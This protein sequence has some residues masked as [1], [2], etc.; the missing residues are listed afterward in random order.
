MGV[1]MVFAA[2]EGQ[3][4]QRQTAAMAATGRLHGVGR[5]GVAGALTPAV[6]EIAIER[7]AMRDD[8]M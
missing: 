8:A 7:D 2:R 6:A 1:M 3:Y 4:R 5:F